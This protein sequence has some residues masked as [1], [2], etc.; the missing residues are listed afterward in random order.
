MIGIANHATHARARD[1]GGSIEKRA[2]VACPTISTF[3]VVVIKVRTFKHVHL[4]ITNFRPEILCDTLP[5]KARG[6]SGIKG[7]R[8]GGGREGGRV[9]E[10][11]S[12]FFAERM[13]AR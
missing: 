3:A 13:A 1:R 8:W 7:D 4:R 2:C 11:G 12:D 5:R 6:V 9:M 10:G